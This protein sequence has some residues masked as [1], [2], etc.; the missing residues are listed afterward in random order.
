M[1][2]SR[3]YGTRKRERQEDASHLTP[4]WQKFFDN[5][6]YKKKAG[7]ISL[8]DSNEKVLS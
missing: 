3:E 6:T 7:T 4:Y 5:C 1:P 8:E 2:K